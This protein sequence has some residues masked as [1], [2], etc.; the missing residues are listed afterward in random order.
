MSRHFS[1]RIFSLVFGCTYALAVVYQL[2]LFYY[3]PAVKQFSLHDMPL[4]SHGPGMSWFGWIATAALAATVAAF[5]L[6]L[7]LPRRWLDRIPSGL[8][9]LVPLAMLIG[10][11]FREQDW[12]FK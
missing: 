1:L 12:L 3:F 11:F 8:F 6:P 5:L 7:I 4:D 10:G 9:W 2:A